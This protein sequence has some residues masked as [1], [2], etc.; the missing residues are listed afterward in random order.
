MKDGKMTPR[1]GS[2]GFLPGTSHY[3]GVGVIIDIAVTYTIISFTNP[4]FRNHYRRY[5]FG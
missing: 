1:N 3:R 4:T 5:N 2:S